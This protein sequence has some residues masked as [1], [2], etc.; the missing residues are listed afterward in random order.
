MIVSS[1]LSATKD[2]EARADDA[3]FA[4]FLGRV[5]S[6]VGRFEDV[7]GAADGK[8]RATVTT[9]SARRRA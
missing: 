2:D 8:N 7:F 1:L 6:T 9:G 3:I 5:Q 4:V